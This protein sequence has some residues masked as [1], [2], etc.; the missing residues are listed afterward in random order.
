MKG[1][2]GRASRPV[3][4]IRESRGSGRR[5]HVGAPLAVRGRGGLPVPEGPSGGGG[6]GAAGDG[7]GRGPC[8][9]IWREGPSRAGSLS[10]F[11]EGPRTAREPAWAAGPRRCQANAVVR[12]RSRTPPPAIAAH[13][14]NRLRREG[15]WT[16]D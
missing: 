2:T 11:R 8:R 9:A 14:G 3:A 13:G 15:V 7:R 5:V 4:G 12:P 1:I 6:E 16:R 10:R